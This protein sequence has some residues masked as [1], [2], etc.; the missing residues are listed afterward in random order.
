MD[1]AAELLA[2]AEALG[3]LG[4]PLGIRIRKFG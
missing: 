2:A 1:C 4:V 3:K